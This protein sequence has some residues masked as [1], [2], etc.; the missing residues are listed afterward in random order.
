[1]KMFLYFHLTDELPFTPREVQIKTEERFED[2][3]DLEK[4]VGK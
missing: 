2:F 4:E 3:Y 1:M